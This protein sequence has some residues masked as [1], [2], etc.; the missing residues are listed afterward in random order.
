MF[1]HQVIEDLKSQYLKL[2]Q[3][4]QENHYMMGVAYGDM[5]P[6]AIKFHFGDAHIILNSSKNDTHVFICNETPIKMPYPI[7]W[8][9]YNN[10]YYGGQSCKV[11]ALVCHYGAEEG[12]IEQYELFSFIF[13]PYQRKWV[14]NPQVYFVK[15]GFMEKYNEV[16]GFSSTDD[17][18]HHEIA[19]ACAW[20]AHKSILLLNCKNIKTENIKAPVSLNKKRRKNGKQEIFNYR[21]GS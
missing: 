13:N 19:S 16:S 3:K 2:S 4:E 12:F 18:I 14:I 10:L 1:A 9:D 8:F 17:Q 15:N 20:L 11:A 5:I 7:M 6:S 21:G